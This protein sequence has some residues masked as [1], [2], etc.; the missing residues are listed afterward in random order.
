MEDLI[1]VMETELPPLSSGLWL[2]EVE[3]V[4]ELCDPGWGFEIW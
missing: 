3:V 4:E 2:V 1:D